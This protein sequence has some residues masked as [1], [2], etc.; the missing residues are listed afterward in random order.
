MNQDSVFPY[1]PEIRRRLAT[2]R[3]TKQTGSI[4]FRRGVYELRYRLRQPDGTWITKC[5][6]LEDAVT[7]RDAK[8]IAEQKMFYINERNNR[9]YKRS[10]GTLEFI[11]S[12]LWN[13]GSSYVYCLQAGDTGRIKIGWTR[14]PAKRFSTFKTHSPERPKLLGIWRGDAEDE[15]AIHAQF[16]DLRCNGEWFEPSVELLQFIRE[17]SEV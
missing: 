10:T 17:K 16:A 7:E 15:R 12:I 9:R 14:T 13:D 3:R 1:T 2:R 4:R 8:R 6:R 11:M 5:E